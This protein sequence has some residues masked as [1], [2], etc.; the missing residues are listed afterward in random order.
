M[1]EQLLWLLFSK[2]EIEMTGIVEMFF[3]G[4]VLLMIF[5]ALTNDNNREWVGIG[6]YDELSYLIWYFWYK[7]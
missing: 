6:G 1:K 5:D 4:I 7:N 2:G 3:C